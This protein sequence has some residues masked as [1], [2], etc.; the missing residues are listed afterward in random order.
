MRETYQKR[1]AKCVEATTIEEDVKMEGID[2]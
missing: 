2:I 1:E